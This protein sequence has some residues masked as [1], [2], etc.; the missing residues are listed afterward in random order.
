VNKLLHNFSNANKST[1]KAVQREGCRN[2]TLGTWEQDIL[3]LQ[4]RHH[5]F[6]AATLD[7]GR[8]WLQPLKYSK[9]EQKIFF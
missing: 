3:T 1:E 7:A 2:K 8:F 4:L 9:L 5:H 6:H